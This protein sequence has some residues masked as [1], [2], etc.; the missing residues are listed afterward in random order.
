M[1]LN[2]YT[3]NF[4]GDR[5]VKITY[6]PLIMSSKP[7]SIREFIYGLNK[8]VICYLASATGFFAFWHRFINPSFR[9]VYFDQKSNELYLRISGIY[10]IDKN[11]DDKGREVIV[12]SILLYIRMHYTTEDN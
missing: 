5:V 8:Y 6:D 2:N 11:L 1:K 3:V 12:N 7:I 10:N 9:L 4:V